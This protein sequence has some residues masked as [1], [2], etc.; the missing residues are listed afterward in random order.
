[1]KKILSLSLVLSMFLVGCDG[2]W[3]KEEH[4]CGGDSCIVSVWEK[5]KVV[6]VEP[7]ENERYAV[8]YKVE[9][10]N[11]YYD[12]DEDGHTHDDLLTHTSDIVCYVMD[13][14]TS[15]YCDFNE[16]TDNKYGDEKKSYIP[17]VNDGIIVY[18]DT[19]ID[20]PT[21]SEEIDGI[22]YLGDEYGN[23]A[24]TVD[25]YP[26]DFSGLVSGEV[27]ATMEDDKIK[28][29]VINDG[30]V[31]KNGDELLLRCQH[32]SVE[33]YEKI[34]NECFDVYYDGDSLL[35]RIEKKINSQEKLE[36][37]EGDVISF[38][39][40]G[41]DAKSYTEAKEGEKVIFTPMVVTLEE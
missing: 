26:Y 40:G 27:I 1:M 31:F 3:R 22:V 12:N 16:Y 36:L 11:V 39:Y 10:Q 38:K 37:K 34:F 28:I 30:E 23:G 41:V 17:Q 32:V 6:K 14:T 2:T 19:Y 24:L 20:L 8:F 18:Y 33:S 15:E 7:K 9:C 25:L 21:W 5:G 29:K 4:V 13:A 35:D